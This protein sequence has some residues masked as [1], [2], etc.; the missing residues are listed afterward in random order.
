MLSRKNNISDKRA[1]YTLKIPGARKNYKSEIN[2]HKLINVMLHETSKIYFY[3]KKYRQINQV[4]KSVKMY[5]LC[6]ASDQVFEIWADEK[7]LEISCIT[8][9]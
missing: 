1:F 4:W 9:L 2:I 8:S 6:T 7:T 3:H 5:S